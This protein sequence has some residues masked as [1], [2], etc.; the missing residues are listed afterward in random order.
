MAHKNNDED[1]S[2][3]ECTLIIV[4]SPVLSSCAALTF[5]SMWKRGHYYE[6]NGENDRATYW[7]GWE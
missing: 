5:S 4:I 6:M 3:K 2:D 7:Y 1:I